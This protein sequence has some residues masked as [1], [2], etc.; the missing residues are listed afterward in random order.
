[1][2]FATNESLQPQSS[3]DTSPSHAAMKWIQAQAPD[4]PLHLQS[5]QLD[6]PRTGVSMH[7][8]TA[9]PVG[10]PVGTVLFVHG[11]PDCF[12]GW[13][14]QI[15]AFVRAGFKC[16]AVDQRGFGE[17]IVVQSLRAKPE[18][19]SHQLAAKDL[20]LVCRAEKVD[21]VIVVGHDWGG[22]V[23]W[24]F[25]RRYPALCRAVVSLCTPY[26][27]RKG[28]H[29]S[30]ED[31]AAIM[32]PFAY[33]VYFCRRRSEAVREFSADPQRML[34]ALF[35][36]GAK[37]DSAGGALMNAQS[38]GFLAHFPPGPIPLSP[39]ISQA[40]IDVYLS[41]LR[42]SGFDSGL[43]W[44]A[45][46]HLNWS[47]D[48]TN[49]REDAF[50][51]RRGD[52]WNALPP[53]ALARVEPVPPAIAQ[54]AL[55]VTAGHDVILKPSMSLGMEEWAPQLKRMHVEGASHWVQAEKPKQVN[56]GILKFIRE[57][58]KDGAQVAAAS[59]ASQTPTR[60]KL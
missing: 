3:A 17:S 46:G 34:A 33:Q 20:Q 19:Y 28:R 15:P 24:S 5:W 54:P 47:E 56:E 57:L 50:D 1:M 58:P 60:S 12:F 48:S 11:W 37:G 27:P 29:L 40:E 13:R 25:A 14:H 32:P 26:R 44:Y 51:V 4:L 39:L 10:P 43:C 9:H 22:A 49:V 35:R 7:Y 59:S 30:V 38:S 41:L 8:V 18:S 36:S 6:L 31:V 53:S 23:V 2:S 55:M 52:Q 45:T 16:I 42:V 21:R